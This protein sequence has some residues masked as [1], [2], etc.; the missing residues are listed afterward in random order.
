LRLADTPKKPN[1]VPEVKRAR[2]RLERRP[3]VSRS[4]DLEKR[5]WVHPGERPDHV[6]HTLVLLESAKVSKGGLR[7]ACRCQRRVALRV[8]AGIDHFDLLARNAAR[9][10]IVARALADRLERDLS[11]DAAERTFGQPHRGGQ[12][13]GK[14]EKG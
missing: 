10:E 2:E 13:R 7:G 9:H 12:R 6:V 1:P 14:L 5:V 11:I 8:D 3:I 4:S